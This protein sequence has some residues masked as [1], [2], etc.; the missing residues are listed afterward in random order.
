MREHSR[1]VE[2]HK[3]DAVSEEYQREQLLMFLTPRLEATRQA[4]ELRIVHIFNSHLRARRELMVD[5][6]STQTVAGL[7]FQGLRI[8]QEAVQAYRESATQQ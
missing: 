2:Y 8:H 1:F 4:I 5:R 3:A 6:N 7:R